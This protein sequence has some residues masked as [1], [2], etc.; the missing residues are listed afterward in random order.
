M[1]RSHRLMTLVATAAL[2]ASVTAAAPSP[3]PA[4]DWIVIEYVLDEGGPIDIGA[5]IAMT[6][7]PADDGQP[8]MLG[9]GLGDD[10]F[11]P[12]IFAA[13]LG[14]GPA[15]VTLNTPVGTQELQ[16]SAGTDG[17]IEAGLSF[18]IHGDRGGSYVVSL[19]V[20]GMDIIEHQIGELEVA[21]GTLLDTRIHRGSGSTAVRSM[22]ADGTA[23][24]AAAGPLAAG[25]SSHEAITSAGII[26]ALAFPSCGT[27]QATWSSPDGREGSIQVVDTPLA[28]QGSG[29]FDF[30][31][32]AGPWSWTWTGVRV[33]S[34]FEIAQPQDAAYVLYAP[35]GELHRRVDGRPDD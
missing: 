32:P 28:S 5:S 33:P 3:A 8:A 22:T 16:L 2:A 11:G 34:A 17:E 19:M 23:T 13:E 20:S 29:W 12:G 25:T 9:F 14:T 4:D 1:R 26:G 15:H 27:C 24:G 10:L 35:I 7:S 30:A 6:L 21:K 31:G 18:G